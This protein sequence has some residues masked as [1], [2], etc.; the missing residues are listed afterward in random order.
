MREIDDYQVCRPN[1][2][3]HFFGDSI[4]PFDILYTLRP[5]THLQSCAS[6][7]LECRFHIFAERCDDKYQPIVH[8]TATDFRSDIRPSQ[9][10][11]TL[12]DLLLEVPCEL[13]SELR[14][15]NR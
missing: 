15:I 1:H 4:I 5:E 14:N 9:C 10:F 3:E 6:D 13:V 7:S 8:V 11:E 2:I 12:V